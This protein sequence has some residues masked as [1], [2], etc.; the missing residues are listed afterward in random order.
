L[1]DFTKTES[2]SE[3]D[4]AELPLL[5][6]TITND[7]ITIPTPEIRI[8]QG[9]TSLPYY[10]DLDELNAIPYT[11][12]IFTAT[13]DDPE[14]STLTVSGTSS[15][16]FSRTETGLGF[17]FL[18]DETADSSDPPTFQLSISGENAANYEFEET[19]IEVEVLDA[20]SGVADISELTVE[21]EYAP[22]S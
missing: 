7:P 21:S 2:L 1:I 13:I 10:F 6:L 8:M 4:Y 15:L 22:T 14:T 19:E 20:E 5:Q 17:V 9:G 18:L 11:E 12:V 3:P 16:V